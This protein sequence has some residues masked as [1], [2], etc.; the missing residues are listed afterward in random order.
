ME[1]RKLGAV[2]LA[3]FAVFLGGLYVAQAAYPKT[4]SVMAYSIAPTAQVQATAL[5]S[6]EAEV[7]VIITLKRP[8]VFSAFTDT[9]QAFVVAMTEDLESIY[10][11]E[12]RN[13]MFTF[14]MVSGTIPRENLIKITADPRVRGVWYDGLI[15]VNVSFSS[16]YEAQSITIDEARV[17]LKLNELGDGSGVNVVVL[18]SGAASSRWVV[19]SDMWAVASGEPA[20][21][22]YGHGSLVSWIIHE[23]SPNSN[24]YSIKVLDRYGMGRVSDVISGIELAL[25][26]VPRP[27]VI[28]M[29][30]GL[31]SSILDPLA[32]S[33]GAAVVWNE[34]VTIIAASGNSGH[35]VVL[36]PAIAD[37][38]IAVG[39]V[40]RNLE[41]L[42][43]SGGGVVGGKIKPDVVSYGVVY[44][45]WL[46]TYKTSAGTSIATPMVTATYARWLSAQ[47]DPEK[48]DARETV[49][50]G[51][52]D[53]GQEGPDTYYGVGGFLSG[54]MLA[55]V[56]GV[57]RETPQGRLVLT[58]PILGLA[59][60]PAVVVWRK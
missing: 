24:L 1:S 14:E 11:F 3:A 39:A 47:E 19:Y 26:E 21:D 51:G 48:F 34:G 4:F 25:R 46:D 40:D 59:C 57:E 27:M 49:V 5:A 32:E 33:A 31:P 37:S 53:L 17:G 52:I 50:Q 16:S 12:T 56:E 38:V 15:R 7:P 29:S 30:L 58:L 54:D 60:I 41:Y 23:L 8:N 10:G 2:L 42:D 20:E 35:G 18:D 45:L 13:Q 6:T 55:Q 44:G 36:S 28:N 22:S 43:F 9:P